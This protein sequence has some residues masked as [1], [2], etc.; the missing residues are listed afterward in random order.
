MSLY[1]FSFLR[2]YTSRHVTYPDTV[3]LPSI[4][5]HYSEGLPLAAIIE[6]PSLT[7]GRLSAQAIVLVQDVIQLKVALLSL[8]PCDDY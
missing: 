7:A 4:S 5:G 6:L 1:G 3:S 8:S 2:E